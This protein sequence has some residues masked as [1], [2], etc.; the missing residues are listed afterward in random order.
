MNKRALAGLGLLLGLGW[1]TARPAAAQ[2]PLDSLDG[3]TGKLLRYEQRGPH[4]KLFLHLDR[5][6]YLSGET[7]WFKIY[8]ADGTRA[9]PLAMS[10]VAYVEVLDAD[11]QP[12]LQT[13]VALQKGSGQGSLALPTALAAGSYTVRAYTSWMKNFSPEAYF[14]RP[15]T[16]INTLSASGAS[17]RDSATS[18]DAQ[19]FPEGGHLVRGIRSRVA[20]KITD[21]AGRGVAAEGKVLN[22]GGA[23]VATFRTLR[24]GM[25][26]F[27]F[28][29]AAGPD[30]YTATITLGPK[31]VLTRPLPAP[32]EQGYVLRLDDTG[33]DQLTLTVNASGAPAE[34]LALLAHS[35]QQVALATREPLRNGQAVFVI[36]KSAL[37]DGVSHL[38]LFNADRKP[39][40]E[41]L[42]FRAP[43]Q[44]LAITG[45]ADKAQYG[46]RDKVSVQVATAALP[47]A[48][49]SNLSMAVYRLDSLTT[50]P[51]PGIDRYLWLTS[52]LQGTVENPDYYFTATGP[53]AAE[54]TDNLLLTQ[55]WS[56]FRW[57]DV[58]AAPKPFEFLA[59]PYGPVIQAQVLRAGTRQPQAGISTYLASPS[60]IVD[61]SVAASNAQG[62]VRFEP[63]RFS[64]PHD[65]VLQTDPGQDSTS[66]L[67]VLS[68][69]SGRYA[70]G[71]R[72]AFG[73]TPRFQ[74]DYARRHF[75]A[76]VQNVF[77]GKYRNRYAAERVDSLAF[78]GKPDETYL[79][80]KFTRFKVMEE[81]LREYVPGVVVRIRKDG[82]HLL[83]VDRINKAV[84]S[85]NPMVL[86]DGVPVFNI[87]K[88]MAFNPLKIRKLDVLDGRYFHGPAVYNG[89]VSFT[90]YKGDLEG[91]PLDPRVL[92]Q[93]YEGVQRQREFYAP[94]YDTPEAAKS[95]LPDLRNLLYWNPDINLTG[96][97]A[98]TLDFYTGDQAGRYLVVLQGLATN[99]LA[100]SRSF[101]LDVKPAL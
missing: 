16:V 73:I 29:P 56:R 35:R 15:I 7:L 90:T 21:K 95:R 58:L 75:Q 54:A 28:T 17:A 49:A 80:D 2:A 81:V 99:G 92:V 87:N 86:L 88:I 18:Y 77:A 57:E 84:L 1:N 11:H 40:C 94:R 69:F 74:Q 60:R 68:P 52:D 78:F 64:G 30:T 39:V 76:Q 42:Y 70:T 71:P 27:D 85:E 82:F 19:F 89:I 23:V 65:I 5:P 79:L 101:V 97:T 53:E 43:Q 33:P 22:Q 36:N 44:L 13:K 9:R 61:L 83:V 98:K 38:T 46:T 3:L 51:G 34:T 45:R 26:H 55:G 24:F 66:L 32:A 48:E 91:F 72:P 59:E 14:H 100:G 93:E 96:P 4:E 8:A 10:S 41:R 67:T 25:G 31:R 63:N 50:T 62:I 37:L 12:V 20:F 47:A 6:V